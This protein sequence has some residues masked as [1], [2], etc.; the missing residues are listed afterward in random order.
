ME[1]NLAHRLQEYH[2]LLSLNRFDAHIERLPTTSFCSASIVILSRCI[3]SCIDVY[4]PYGSVE[5]AD[6]EKSTSLALL[7]DLCFDP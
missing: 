6:F 4:L 2:T 1:C 3:G 5:R 7:A